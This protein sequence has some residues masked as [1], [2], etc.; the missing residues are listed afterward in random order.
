MTIDYKKKYLR[1]KKKYLQAKQ[2]FEGGAAGLAQAGQITVTVMN[3]ADNQEIELQVSPMHSVHHVIRAN[4]GRHSNTEVWHGL[5]EVDPQASFQSA[6]IQ[7]GDRLEVKFIE[8]SGD[9]YRDMFASF[10]MEKEKRK[11]PYWQHKDEELRTAGWEH[12]A[13]MR[14]KADAE[15]RDWRVNEYLDP[16]SSKHWSKAPPYLGSWESAQQRFQRTGYFLD[17]SSALMNGLGIPYRASPP[18]MKGD[19]FGVQKPHGV[20]SPGP[21]DAVMYGKDKAAAMKQD[22]AAAE[23]ERYR[24]IQRHIDEREEQGWRQNITPDHLEYLWTNRWNNDVWRQYTQIFGDNQVEQA[25]ALI[26]DRLRENATNHDEQMLAQQAWENRHQQDALNLYTSIFG[27]ER[28]EALKQRI[29][30]SHT[31]GHRGGGRKLFTKKK[32]G[33]NKKK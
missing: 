19:T 12:L 2:T 28:G 24:G 16:N 23:Q 4:F 31:A 3:L 18:R 32:H 21:F 27:A 5:E 1:Y 15:G 14:A 30:A 10:A 20:R 13:Q 29:I 7:N 33:G 25:R 8:M 11:D 17:D 26:H 9:Y 22:Y 6:G